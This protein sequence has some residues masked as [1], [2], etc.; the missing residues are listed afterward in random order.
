MVLVRREVEKFDPFV[1]FYFLC[2]GSDLFLIPA[3]TDIGN[4]F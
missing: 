4:T 2:N 3:L 1:F